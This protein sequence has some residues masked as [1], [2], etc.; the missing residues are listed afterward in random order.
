M[1]AYMIKIT[2]C[3]NRESTAAIV[4]EIVL[5]IDDWSSDS[6]MDGGIKNES[7]RVLVF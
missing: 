7:L 2:G 1:C 4:V 5:F 6:G 3:N